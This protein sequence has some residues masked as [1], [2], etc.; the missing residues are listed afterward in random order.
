MES[1]DAESSME[2]LESTQANLVGECLVHD[3]SNVSSKLNWRKWW[4]WRLCWQWWRKFH[5]LHPC[6][7]LSIVFE[8][9]QN[10][11]DLEDLTNGAFELFMVCSYVM[12]RNIFKSIT[13]MLR[14]TWLLPFDKTFQRSS[15]HCGEQGFTLVNE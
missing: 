2:M 13:R 3:F 8:H 4:W 6:G 15:T 12:V 5:M 14:A 9:F 10:S 7:P 1:N 11:F